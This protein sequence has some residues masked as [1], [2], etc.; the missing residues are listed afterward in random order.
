MLLTTYNT[1]QI[2]NDVTYAKIRSCKNFYSDFNLLNRI[3]FTE[4][5]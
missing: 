3:E 2:L 5:E 1:V 4:L